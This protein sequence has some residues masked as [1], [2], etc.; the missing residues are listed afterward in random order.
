MYL[1]CGTFGAVNK[2]KE[3]AL[4]TENVSHKILMVRSVKS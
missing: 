1:R 4:R 3:Y 2:I